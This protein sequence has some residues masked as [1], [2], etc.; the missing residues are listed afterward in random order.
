MMEVEWEKNT[1]DQHSG[2]PLSQCKQVK[3]GNHFVALMKQ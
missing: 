3:L 1:D 2:K